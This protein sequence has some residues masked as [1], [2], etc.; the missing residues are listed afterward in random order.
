MRTADPLRQASYPNSVLGRGLMTTETILT[1]NSSSIFARQLVAL[2]FFQREIPPTVYLLIKHTESETIISV[3]IQA[4]P[5]FLSTTD[6]QQ[7]IPGT[8][9]LKRRVLVR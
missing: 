3:P 2:E 1:N 9:A 5:T 7:P 6:I 4:S 8:G